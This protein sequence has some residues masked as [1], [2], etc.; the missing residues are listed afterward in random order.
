MSASLRPARALPSVAV[1]ESSN[2]ATKFCPLCYSRMMDNH[3][4]KSLG[5]PR[6]SLDVR[7]MNFAC[8]IP[9]YSYNSMGRPT[10]SIWDCVRNMTVCYSQ[11][12]WDVKQ[13]LGE[14]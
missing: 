12:E 3:K 11:Q 6:T 2:V 8:K 4:K 14:A 7:D 1:P 10:V 13:S 5:D 9:L